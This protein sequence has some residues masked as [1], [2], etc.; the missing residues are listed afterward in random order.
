MSNDLI[1][2]T[3]DKVIQ[4]DLSNS[5]RLRFYIVENFKEIILRMDISKKSVEDYTKRLSRFIFFLEGTELSEDI[6]IRY[7]KHLKKEYAQ[8]TASTLDAYLSAAKVIFRQL[9]LE[10][11][12]RVNLA[13]RVKGFKF[14]KWT[15]QPFRSAD[16]EKLLNVIEQFEPAA[17]RLRQKA[18]FYVLVFQGLRSAELVTMK[19]DHIDLKIGTFKIKPKGKDGLEDRI[20]QGIVLDAVKEYLN[21]EGRKT[22]FLFASI[23]KKNKGG[24][25]GTSTVRNYL[26]KLC[27]LAGVD[28]QGLHGFRRAL[29]SRLNE[30]GVEIV[31]IKDIL[32]HA[33]I[34]TTAGY[35][36]KIN[37]IESMK[38]ALA[39]DT[40][41]K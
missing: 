26:R 33:S 25:I 16:I 34:S 39:K 32:G 18:M 27:Q 5:E 41:L 31:S 9:Y 38:K 30:A 7:K 20:F 15:R 23:A 17:K 13:E 4:S 1:I 35:I 8:N 3:S 24:Q 11:K 37:K 6:L 29:A 21:Q 28:N 12:I 36:R 14:E 19:I 10:G 2:L 22:G 40:L